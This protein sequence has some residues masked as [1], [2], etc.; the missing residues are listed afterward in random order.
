[1]DELIDNQFKK[2]Q[3][4][5]DFRVFLEYE[6]GKIKDVLNEDKVNYMKFSLLLNDLEKLETALRWTK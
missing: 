4:K 5:T 2:T 1:M 3:T 6:I